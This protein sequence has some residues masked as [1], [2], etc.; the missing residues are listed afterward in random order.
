[1]EKQKVFVQV[2]ESY[3]ER[4]IAQHVELVIMDI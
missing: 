1:M 2:E 3:D 4:E